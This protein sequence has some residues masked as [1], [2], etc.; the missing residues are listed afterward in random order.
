MMNLFNQFI[1]S[2]L[3]LLLLLI[4]F[5][6][7]VPAKSQTPKMM[8]VVIDGARYTETFGD[9]DFTF[10]PKMAELAAGGTIADAFRNDGITYTSRAIPALWSGA[11]TEVRDTVYGGIET[12]YAVKPS[13]FEHYRK[14]TGTP[15]GSCFY[16]LKYISGLW[17]PSFDADY[18][19]QYWPAFYSAG[20]G[21][22]A[23]CNNTKYLMNV[24]QPD[25]LWV[26]LA[27]VDNAGHTGDW[28]YYT[29]A[30]L[31]ADSIVGE[32]WDHIQSSAYYRNATTI[33]V[34]NDHGRHDDQHG[35]FQHH[36]CG[37]EG[38]RRIQFLAVGPNIKPNHVST[39]PRTLLD[40][41]VTAAHILG[42]EMEHATGEVMHEILSANSIPQQQDDLPDPALH[43][44]PNPATGFITVRLHIEQPAHGIATLYSLAGS[45]LVTLD[46]GLLQPGEHAFTIDLPDGQNG[47]LP[48][49]VYLLAV[50]AGEKL[51]TE[52]VVVKNPAGYWL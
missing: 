37:C 7:A 44:T 34:T 39:V 15:S 35:G 13:I 49:G 10:I 38:C 21:D 45:P 11:W 33:I 42:F 52:K 8:I 6:L 27:D 19:P 9:P 3:K 12:S 4:V 43:I 16:V 23:V 1:K 46:I 30:L 29:T 24:D 18:G 5:L 20:A 2:N 51:I 22:E 40:M 48:P 17:L 32:L 41:A 26:Y 47:Q 31:K 36:G 14:H 28:D 25:F 50:Q